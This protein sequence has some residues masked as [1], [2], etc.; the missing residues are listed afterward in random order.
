MHSSIIR[1]CSISRRS[2]KKISQLLDRQSNFTLYLQILTLFRPKEH[3][4]DLMTMEECLSKYP[5]AIDDDSHRTHMNI[6]S[7]ELSERREFVAQIN[8]L[9]QKKEDLK[10]EV[11][12]EESFL[13]S[14]RNHLESILDSA[15]PL[16]LH[17]GL[18]APE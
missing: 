18:V 1:T 6:L 2:S 4:V 17:L 13:N 15:D 8:S 14:I 3:A 9:R 5:D 7:H 10:S 12:D 11:A 16:R